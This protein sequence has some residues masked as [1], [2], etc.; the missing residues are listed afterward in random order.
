MRL[1][2]IIVPVYNRPHEI[3][4][5]LESLTHQ[6]Y[7]NF[8]VI[9]V[10]DGS[11]IS[12]QE[13]VEKYKDKMKIQYFYISNVRQGFA[14]NYGFSKANGDYFIVFDSD[15]IIPENY[16]EEVHKNLTTHK[17][18]AFGGPDAAHPKF[19]P[20]QKAISYSMTSPFTTGGIR[21]NKKQMDTYYPR[22]FNLGISREVWEKTGGFKWTSGS[23]DIEFS[24]RIYSLGFKVG[25]IPEALVYHK[26][27]STFG[28]F[29]KQLNGFGG[30][31]I[32]LYRHFPDQLKLVHFFPAIFTLG[33]LFTVLC[34]IFSFLMPESTFQNIVY[35]L[36]S[37]S[38]F[39]YLLWSILIMVHSS[40]LNKSLYI[41]ILSLIAAYVQLV[42]YGVGFLNTAFSSKYKTT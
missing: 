23:E 37:I 39:A 17:W 5:L 4:E 27:R 38:G 9:V 13:W 15:C 24:R 21:G 35:R 10:E 30:G 14:R 33:I 22:S 2:S 31:R 3:D 26:R 18:D 8:E 41:G 16:L 25:L 40:I 32:K 7:K 6:R 11:S 42:G 20:T 19:N 28:L 12:S 34:G 1:F 36:F 29:Y